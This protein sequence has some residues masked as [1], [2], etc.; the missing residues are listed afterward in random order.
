MLAELTN[1]I[2]SALLLIG[3]GALFGRV[4]LLSREDVPKLNNIVV[5]LAFPALIFQSIL[6]AD[7]SVRFLIIPAVAWVVMLAS[8]GLAYAAGRLMRLERKVLGGF[9]LLSSFGNTGFLGYPLALA[10]FGGN[11]L[12]HAFFY[13]IF[14]GVMFVLS[15]GLYLGEVYGH[16]EPGPAE[17]GPAASRRSKFAQM[18]TFPPFI[19][20][21]AALIVK[22]MTTQQPPS[23]V[24][25]PIGYLAGAAIP[26]IM[27][28]V[29]L[30]LRTGEIKRYVKPLAVVVILKLLLAPILAVAVSLIVGVSGPMLGV[31]ALMASMP[32]GML[33]IVIG[34]QYRLDDDFIAGGLM[35]TT[36]LSVITVPLV[37]LGLKVTAP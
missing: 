37:Q 32:S 28:S 6:S 5:Y 2:V 8:L 15:V 7:L 11:G 34:L 1:G 19:A 9:L 16:D 24:M 27:F 26:L 3:L 17:P 25:A 21:V 30:S 20:L 4:K 13:D 22:N 23:L 35:V 12:V 18:M 14:G 36:V 10:A 29:G 33:A 31:V